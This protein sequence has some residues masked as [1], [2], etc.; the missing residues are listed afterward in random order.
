MSKPKKIGAPLGVAPP[1][2]AP[3][4]IGKARGIY[5]PPEDAPLTCLRCIHCRV[6]SETDWSR[7][8]AGEGENKR[9]D[10]SAIV[11]IHCAKSK[12]ARPAFI[13]SGCTFA[14]GRIHKSEQTRRAQRQ[15]GDRSFYC[16]GAE[17][18]FL[19]LHYFDA[20]LD[21]LRRVTQRDAKGL[22]KLARRLGLSKSPARVLEAIRQGTAAAR[23]MVTAPRFNEAQ[24]AFILECDETGFWPRKGDPIGNKQRNAE[25]KRQIVEGVA[26]RGDAFAWESIRR[27]KEEHQPGQK[28]WRAAWDERK[29]R[30]KGGYLDRTEQPK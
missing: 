24:R 4:Q 8:F 16:T 5:R 6:T 30:K 21:D 15:S 22:G 26:A 1:G 27:F 17:R 12:R 28:R 3:D 29:R 11:P 14:D 7:A 10:E 13:W 18:L 23:A 9:P 19:R 25:T 2:E 20:A